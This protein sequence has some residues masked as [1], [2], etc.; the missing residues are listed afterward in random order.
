MEHHFDG[1]TYRAEWDYD[2]LKGSLQ[3]TFYTLLDGELHHVLDLRKVGGDAAATRVRD[4]RKAWC[5]SMRIETV[6]GEKGGTKRERMASYRLDLTSV[7][8]FW[9][10][11]ILNG[12]VRAPKEKDDLPEDR[13]ALHELLKAAIEEVVQLED[14]Q[15][16]KTAIK[17]LW[18][19]IHQH[20]TPA[21]DSGAPEGHP[22]K[23]PES[24]GDTL[25]DLFYDDHHEETEVVVGPSV[26][27]LDEDEGADEE[28]NED[29]T[30]IMQ[31][32]MEDAGL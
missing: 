3:R 32:M 9:A 30:S 6:K 5:G 7:R 14:T 28:E 12:E 24:V 26:D 31:S 13:D 25:A 19:L 20:K 17:D 18:K 16:A 1:E 23:E 11:Q 15:H 2:R 8:P 21:P 22:D 10:R 29:I 4:L 27:V